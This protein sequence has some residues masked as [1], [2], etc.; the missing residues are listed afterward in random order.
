MFPDE[1][2][3]A[4]AA[5]PVAYLPYGLC[6][7]HGPQNALGLDALK[8]HAVCVRA[9]RESGGIVAPPSYW[10]IQELGISGA[11]SHQEIGQVERTW[12]T[13]IPPWQ[14]YRN[15][16]YQ[17]RTLDSHGF[18]AG[19]LVTGHDAWTDD[20]VRL[21]ELIQPHVGT[22]LLGIGDW[23]GNPDGVDHA[24]RIE[25]SLLWALEPDCVDVSRLPPADAPGPHWAMGADARGADRRD[26][27][28]MAATEAAHLA[29]QAR[30]LRDAY[31]ATT[32]RHRL[33]TYADV[34]R[35]WTEIVLPVVPEL[36]SMRDGGEAWLAVPEGSRWFA[37]WR[38][39]Y[40][41]IR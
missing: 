31:S 17:V 21:V 5:A 2:E 14:H 33:R 13:A 15:V 36:L 6:E 11:W 29:Q 27:E 32:P 26:G 8:V 39:P 4:F 37:N 20:L 1:L 23:A 38:V 9:A 30:R 22:R 25:T 40:D 35:V 16:L 18:H 3:A 34:E 28:A 10:H 7:P 19:L 12:L 24:G 41:A